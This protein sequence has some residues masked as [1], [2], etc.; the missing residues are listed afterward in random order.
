ML[1]KL[2]AL[3][4]ET[5]GMLDAFDVKLSMIRCIVDHIISNEPVMKDE[6]L[7]CLDDLIGELGE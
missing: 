3:L 4:E 1:D 5:D 2:R 6:I 7:I